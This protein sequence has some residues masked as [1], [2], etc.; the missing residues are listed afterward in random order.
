M[1]NKTLLTSKNL[2][3][4]LIKDFLPIAITTTILAPIE[5]LKLILQ[6]INLMSIQDKNLNI[7]ILSK[8]KK[9]N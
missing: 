1:D 8:S 9:M 2:Y 7:N 4:H 5:R 3:N 6:T